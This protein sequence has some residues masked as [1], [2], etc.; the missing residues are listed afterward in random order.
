MKISCIEPL[1]INV[2]QFESLKVEFAEQ[3]HD[4]IYYMDRKEEAEV[5]VNRMRDADVVIVSNI[6]LTAEVLSQCSSLKFLSV[7]FTGLD[8]IDLDFCRQ[9]DIAVQNA[10]GYST[11]AVSELAVGL[12]LDLLRRITEFDSITRRGM[13]RGLFLGR[14]LKG[15][16]VGII[17]TGAIGIATAR[18]L[19]AFGSRV[20]AYSRSQRQEISDLGIPYVSLP[21]L[22]ERSDIISLHIPLNAATRHLIGEKELA[23]MKPDAL[24]INTARGDVMDIDA[25]AE[26]LKD[27]RIAGVAT[28]VYE[29]EP[30]LCL[31][32]VLLNAPN[33]ICLPHVGYA[34]RESFDVRADIV[35]NHVKEWLG[36]R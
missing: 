31:Q 4:F 14:E 18:L 19:L 29:Q 24:L 12:M 21:N 26:A 36:G 13:G 33:C 16:T 3:G 27:G 32:H 20:L 30:P 22:L 28:D 6:K 35:F 10:A 2:E 23:L 8:H 25:V 7:A 9:H 5:L 34:T 15:K 11:T 17:G 1:G